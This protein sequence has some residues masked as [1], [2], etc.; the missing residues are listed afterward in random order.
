M[1]KLTP[2]D[3]YRIVKAYEA[4]ITIESIAACYDTATIQ[5][6][7]NAYWDLKIEVSNG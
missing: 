6:I 5:Q 2:Q 3:C 7:I 1:N 4:G